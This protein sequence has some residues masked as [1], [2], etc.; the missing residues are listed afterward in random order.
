M[1]LIGGL[2]RCQTPAT[3]GTQ[4]SASRP[5]Q[6]FLVCD[7]SWLIQNVPGRRANRDSRCLTDSSMPFPQ[8]WSRLRAKM[9]CPESKASPASAVATCRTAGVQSAL[10]VPCPAAGEPLRD[11][12][13]LRHFP[14][15]GW[16]RCETALPPGASGRSRQKSVQ[17][18]GEGGVCRVAMSTPVRILF[19]LQPFVAAQNSFRPWTDEPGQNPDRPPRE[20][21]PI[22]L[23]EGRPPDPD[24]RASP[25]HSAF[26]AERPEGSESLHRIGLFPP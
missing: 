19:G 20:Y 5:L 14:A 24:N 6:S 4:A 1:P 18:R 3:S 25:G 21:Q 16:S 13:P 10:R 12:T 2:E 7:T 11:D 9:P 8:R 17:V 23:R 22:V 26:S 15:A